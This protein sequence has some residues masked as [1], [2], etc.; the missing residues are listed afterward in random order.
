MS[1]QSFI[2][3]DP[4][5]ATVE[6]LVDKAFYGVFINK[7]TGKMIVD[8][9]AGDEPIRLPDA[10]SQT[11]EDYVNWVWTYNTF[12][13]SWGTNGHLILEVL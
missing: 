2:T 3:V 10:Y 12:Q 4:G 9:I 8:R 7:T 6:D 5:S 1:T 11:N 13:F